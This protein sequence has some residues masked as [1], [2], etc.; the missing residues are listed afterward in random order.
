MSVSFPA[1]FDYRTYV[2]RPENADLVGLSELEARRHFEHFG[3]C[4]GRVCS[5]VDSRAAFLGLVPGG[6]LLEIGPFFAPGFSKDERKVEYLDALSTAE[7]VERARTLPAARERK[8]PQIDYVWRGQS[9]AQLISKRFDSA[10]SSHVIEH[11]TCLIRHL[12]DVSSVLLDGGRYFLAIPDKRYCFDHFLPETTI[13]DL[14][15]A[16]SENRVHHSVRSVIEHHFLITHNDPQRHWAGDSGQNPAQA[17]LGRE[18]AAKL[19]EEVRQLQEEKAYVDVHAWKFTPDSFRSVMHNLFALRLTDFRVERV[20]HT[21]KGKNEF[22]AILHK[23]PASDVLT[24]PPPKLDHG[25]GQ[26]ERNVADWAD[27]PGC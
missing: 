5:P 8:I 16:Y 24:I 17:E 4:E 10:F 15:E 22:Y 26:V 2:C 18:R 20:Y 9:Y 3:K 23:V 6:T 27:E 21:L 11:Q 13:A 19:L 7:L 25:R 1:D 14:L 12:R